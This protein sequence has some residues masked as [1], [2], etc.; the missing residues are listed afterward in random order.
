VDGIKEQ[1]VA[2]IA[3][4]RRVFFMAVFVCWSFVGKG[5]GCPSENV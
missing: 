1:R 3:N 5:R 4:E 2:I